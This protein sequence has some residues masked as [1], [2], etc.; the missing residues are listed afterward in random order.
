VQGQDEEQHSDITNAIGQPLQKI[1]NESVLICK[2]SHFLFLLS[3]CLSLEMQS[4]ASKAAIIAA[5]LQYSKEPFRLRHTWFGFLPRMSM[6]WL[7]K[8]RSLGFGSGESKKY[9]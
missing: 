4:P 3:V 2:G 1:N 9:H 6:Q 5:C 8:A 7:P